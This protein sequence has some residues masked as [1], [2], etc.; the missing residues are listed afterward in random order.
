VSC[1]LRSGRS[2]RVG[3]A[4]FGRT[5]SRPAAGWSGGPRT[6]DYA[7]GAAAFWHRRRRNVVLSARVLRT[8]A[9]PPN[10]PTPQ[11]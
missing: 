1:E 5:R 2:G 4:E 8:I 6:T 3:S 7:S 9:S 11:T 10:R